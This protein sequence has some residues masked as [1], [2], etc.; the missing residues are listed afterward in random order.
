MIYSHFSSV[1]D[2]FTLHTHG[3][4]VLALSGGVDSR[5]LL[6][7]LA[8]YRSKHP[9]LICQVVHVHHGLSD[10]A[11]SW[12]EQCAVWCEE[13][14]FDFKVERVTL[15]LGNQISTEQEARVHR[16]QVLEKYVAEGD[17]LLTGQHATDQVETFLLALKRGSGPKGL[18][19]MPVS[20][21]FSQG[22]LVRPLL[23]ISRQQVYQFAQDEKLDWLEDESN[24]DIKFD[25][26]FLRHHVVPVLTE[27]WPEIEKSVG[28]SA[29][30]CAEQE[31]LVNELLEEKLSF[32]LQADK[33]LA[34][35]ALSQQS[36]LARKQLI[37][38]W[39]KRQSCLMPSY[40]QLELI[41]SEVAQAKKD[42]NPTLGIASG[43]I[44][45][46]QHAL[47]FVAPHC[48]VSH[49]TGE[50]HWQ[51][52]LKLPDN[53]GELLFVSIERS[54]AEGTANERVEKMTLRTPSEE[55][56]VSVTFAPEG[57]LAHP[58]TRTHSRKLKKLYQEY[59]VPTWLRKRTPIIMYNDKIAMVGDLF[60][61]KNFHG[62]DC[63]IVWNKV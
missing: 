10:N 20:T 14:S 12:S 7:L 38:M 25:R 16:Y 24:N 57:L 42:A 52:P 40:K 30:L 29:K 62:H 4:V 53:L 9:S 36:E 23:A 58:A 43:T 6:H 51:Q 60:V 35:D 37:R 61:D 11:D 48:D 55:E 46:F 49:W 3:K 21:V 54:Q 18:S 45:R 63:E 1:L 2:S 19:S 47:Y 17:V 41:W 34:I 32:C 44:R 22:H 33:S 15:N 56:T 31:Q 5:V 27:R 59:G 39:L 13:Y 28:R 50:L 26:N 8:H